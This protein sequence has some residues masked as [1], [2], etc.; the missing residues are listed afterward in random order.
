MESANWRMKSRAAFPLALYP[1]LL[2]GTVLL[3]IDPRPPVPVPFDLHA[4][5]PPSSTLSAFSPFAFSLG[6][7]LVTF[8]CQ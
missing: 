7:P 2:N 5:S 3:K 1:N 6:L 8:A 4:H